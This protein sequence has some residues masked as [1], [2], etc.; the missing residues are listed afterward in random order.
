MT[1]HRIPVCFGPVPGQ[2]TAGLLALPLATGPAW[3]SA[4]DAS[5]AATDLPFA[6]VTRSAAV[7]AQAATSAGLYDR[8]ITGWTYDGCAQPADAGPVWSLTLACIP[9]LMN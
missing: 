4:K 9:I 1:P 6:V 8:Q 3:S 7:N 2:V 5:S